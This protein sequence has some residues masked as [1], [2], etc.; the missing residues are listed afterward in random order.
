MFTVN[1]TEL[2]VHEKHYKA[3]SYLQRAWVDILGGDW[4][5]LVTHTLF[6]ITL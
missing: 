6:I 4:P 5:A 1:D 3:L 2:W